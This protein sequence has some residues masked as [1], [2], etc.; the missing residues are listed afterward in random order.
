MNKYFHTAVLLAAVLVLALAPVAGC[1]PGNGEDVETDLEEDHGLT[2]P[3]ADD[4]DEDPGE[5]A[6]KDTE[7]PVTPVDE[8][9]VDGALLYFGKTA[10]EI[11]SELGEP[12]EIDFHEGSEYYYYEKMHMAVFFW[13]DLPGGDEIVRAV[14]LLEDWSVAG[15]SDGMTVAE[16][17]DVLGE[18]FDEE[19]EGEQYLLIIDYDLFRFFFYS[20]SETAPVTN[21]LIKYLDDC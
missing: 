8:T 11:I 6:D 7:D 1:V 18:P 20:D 5:T 2:E 13:P 4:N 15:V 12:S 21:V 9:V 17:K 16:V 3:E 19:M 14:S 10:A